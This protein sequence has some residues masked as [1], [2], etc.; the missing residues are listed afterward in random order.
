MMVD[1]SNMVW[2]SRTRFGLGSDPYARYYPSYPM[3]RVGNQPNRFNSALRINSSPVE[4]RRP[5]HD[6]SLHLDQAS[7]TRGNEVSNDKGKNPIE[8]LS[9]PTC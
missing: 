3:N 8:P 1:R 2:Q 9:P 6:L 5:A 7:N 4:K